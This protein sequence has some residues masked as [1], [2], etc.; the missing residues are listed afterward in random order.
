MW[1]YRKVS[2]D[3]RITKVVK[4]GRDLVSHSLL[5]NQKGSIGIGR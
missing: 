1:I 5:G 4:G 2:C 3:N